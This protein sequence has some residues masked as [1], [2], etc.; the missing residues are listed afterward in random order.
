MALVSSCFIL[1][2]ITMMLSS[3]CQRASFHMI[4]VERPSFNLGAQLLIITL[5]LLSS[6]LICRL[7]HIF[8]PQRPC[9]PDEDLSCS[10]CSKS[11]HNYAICPGVVRVSDGISS[12]CLA[13][14]QVPWACP[15]TDPWLSCCPRTLHGPAEGSKQGVSCPYVLLDWF[16]STP[17]YFR[18]Q[19]RRFM[20][21]V[22]MAGT[23]PQWTHLEYKRN[24]VSAITSKRGVIHVSSDSIAR[25][26]LVWGWKSSNPVRDFLRSH[27]W[28]ACLY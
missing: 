25:T 4:I 20:G 27:P 19:S 11:C 24:T 7:P 22:T 9:P 3:E 17:S 23:W 14:N 21:K 10:W 2:D 6:F 12:T 16:H 18:I 5:D 26:F 8:L 28:G 1:G 15:P 13:W